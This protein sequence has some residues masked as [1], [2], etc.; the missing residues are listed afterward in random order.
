[1]AERCI[2]ACRKEFR[3]YDTSFSTFK[4]IG[5]AIVWGVFGVL[6]YRRMAEGMLTA[7]TVQAG[8]GLLLRLILLP[9]LIFWLLLR[10]LY[11]DNN[12]KVESSNEQ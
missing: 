9:G 3:W 8:L 12:D 10:F 7:E 4:W 1:M 6:A 5:F 11:R 2:V